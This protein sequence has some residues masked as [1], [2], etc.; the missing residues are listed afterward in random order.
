MLLFFT[1][2]LWRTFA[3]VQEVVSIHYSELAV[4]TFVKGCFAVVLQLLNMAYIYFNASR[5]SLFFY[6]HFGH[7]QEKPSFSSRNQGHP[8]WEIHKQMIIFWGEWFLEKS[9][10]SVFKPSAHKSWIYNVCSCHL[11]FDAIKCIV[12]RCCYSAEVS[13]MLLDLT[14]STAS[15][16]P[17][18]EPVFIFGAFS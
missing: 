4:K 5:L 13:F 2:N 8:Q 10:C 16:K 17:K 11:R 12:G 9:L 14:I 1:L 3:C 6:L 7:M 15:L 18:E